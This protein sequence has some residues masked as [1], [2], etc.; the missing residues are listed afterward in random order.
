MRNQRT[1]AFGIVAA[2]TLASIMSACGQTSD[3][4]SI[5]ES[6]E[7]EVVTSEKY[8]QVTEVDGS[9]IT[10]QL[11][12]IEEPDMSGAPNGDNAG[13]GNAPSGEAPEKPDG[14]NAGDGNAPG[15]NGE[16][17]APGEMDFSDMFTAGDETYT[18]VVDDE[19][20][21]DGL[22]LSEIE[23]GDILVLTMD[24]DEKLISVS[25]YEGNGGMGGGPG[26]SDN[27][28]IT[29]TAV[30]TYTEDTKTDGE[31]YESTGKDEEAVLV[32]NGAT[33]TINNPIVN[34]TSDESTGGD[35]SSFYGVGAGVLALDGT[36]TI[37]GGTIT[38]D[39]AGGAGV[40]AYGDGVV[41]ISD[42]TIRT[43]KDTS[44]GIHV[45]GG[46]T[47]HASNLDVETNGASAAAIRSDRG[48]G[49]M[50][51]DGGTYTSN[52]SGSP[53]VYCTADITVD[54]A[55]LEA[56][57][58]EAVC[59]EGL[60]SLVLKNVDLTGNM[61][62]DDQN[63]IT[64]TVIL[65]QSMSGDSE[66]GTSVFN[67]T[68]GSLTSKNGGM[69]YTTNTES[70]FYLSGVTLNY[71][72][73]DDFLLQCTGNANKR[74]WGSTGSNGA[75]CT[76]TADDQE[77]QGV[78]VYDS[79]STLDF[80]L[81]NGSTFTGTF[82]DDESYAGNGGD[83]TCDVTIDET[84]TWVVTED[85]TVSSLTGSGKIVDENGKTVTIQG[86]D[87]TVYVKGT[88]NVTVTVGSYEA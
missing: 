30:T 82:R 58:S 2:L 15:E 8:G 70:E 20:I 18:F 9:S 14:D 73:D 21:L 17:G 86:A 79:I 42:T 23:E 38:T 36:V 53:A 59:I 49:T 33:V 31:T 13:D 35:N 66:V 54:D 24:E 48:G 40:F 3:T 69:F 22:T 76:F 19:S 6:T 84:S 65:Y 47:L 5:V 46:G 39:S 81:Q 16:G 55:T 57:G 4:D 60:N 37:N 10:V 62:D 78:I 67:M 50:T 7:A 63:D 29:Y 52:G 87:G 88:G 27:S 1:K 41:N 74:G 51:V 25:A 12:T 64:W 43:S 72:D 77:L 85:C 28:S 80:I 75:Q 45:A 32:D 61:P 11:G 83:G 56:T 68:G 34:R 44:G 71:S 26:G